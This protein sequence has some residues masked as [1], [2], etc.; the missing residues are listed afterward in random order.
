MYTGLLHTH[1][2]VVILFLLLYLVKL[3]LLLM[4]R[5]ETLAT[6]TKRTRIPEMVISTLFLLTGIGMLFMVAE[7]NTLHIVKILMVLAAIPVAVIGFRKA[8]KLLATLSVLLIIGSYGLAE[9]N[10]IG[11]ADAQITS[12]ETDPSAAGYDQVAHGQAL[13][14]RNCVV[15]HGTDGKKQGSGAKDLTVSQL[16]AEEMHTLIANGKKTMPAYGEL[17]SEAEIAAAIAY[18]KT[19]RK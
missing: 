10:K 8:N 15:C 19:F 4:G 3:V 13:Y 9:M 17:Y 18:V 16:S 11:V 5:E 7:I 6:F 1:R 2:L 14:E 12:V